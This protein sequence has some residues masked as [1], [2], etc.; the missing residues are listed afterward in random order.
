MAD[1]IKAEENKD[2]VTIIG[3]SELREEKERNANSV[4]EELEA[5]EEENN[6]EL[7]YSSLAG[8]VKESFRIN[9]DAR[10]NSG[11][12]QEMIDSMYDVN[13]EYTG[14]DIARIR[15][16][17]HGSTIFMN[18]PMQKCSVLSQ[19]VKD[20][21]LGKDR[22]WDF[23]PSPVKDLPPEI[24]MQ[25][26]QQV[27]M[28]FGEYV[29]RK[30]EEKQAAYQQQVQAAQKNGGPA[31]SA[32]EAS[33]TLRELNQIRRDIIDATMNEID[34]EAL[35]QAKFIKAQVED[36]LVEG[37][38][39]EALDEFIDYFSVFPTAFMKG[40][41]IVKKKKTTW[42][43]GRPTATEEYCFENKCPS[44][45]DMYP[46]PNQTTIEDG[47]LIEHVRY[48]RKEVYDLLKMPE[49]AGYKKDAIEEVLD[50]QVPNESGYP[51]W[52][53]DQIE[54]DKAVTEK[55]GYQ[56]EA[57]TNVIHGMHA[58]MSVPARL[59]I[60]WGFK[61]EDLEGAVGNEE[62]STEI[63][64][65]DEEVIKCKVLRDPFF[66]RPYY[67]ASFKP[68][69]GSFWGRSLPALMKSSTRMCNAT[70]RAL[71]NNMGISSGPQVEVNIDRLADDGSIESMYPWKIWQT[72]SDMIGGAG[73]AVNFFQ[74]S[75]NANDLLGVYK[76]FEQ[77]GDDVTG[78]PKFLS[79]GDGSTPS[80][81]PALSLSVL[82]SQATKGIKRSVE[83]I[84]LGVIN[85]RVK[86]QFY[87]N[88][89]KNPN[90]T[91]TGD[92]NIVPVP[93][94]EQASEKLRRNEFLQITANP[95]DQ[96]IMGDEGR[97]ALIREISKDLGMTE[98]IVPTRMEIAINSE[99]RQQAQQ[100]AQQSAQELEMQKAQ[101]G[102]QSTDRQIS[103]QESMHQ[104]SLQQDE[105]EMQ[106]DYQKHQEELAVEMQKLQADVATNQMG[107][108][109]TVAKQ[110][111]ADDTKKTMF[112]KELA[113]KLRTGK[114][115][116]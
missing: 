105:Q 11:I 34:K 80:S 55:R 68:I 47:D 62:I 60:E 17:E 111:M 106:L 79:G 2:G 77:K 54:S 90:L 87:W 57:N 5:M 100:Q 102:Y 36:D 22:V 70:A 88:L 15:E 83:N 29:K 8:H 94:I 14:K 85:P 33:Y 72:K 44:P 32:V 99:K 13:G 41:I 16:V 93:V 9:Q 51:S 64:L 65:I 25:I 59:L 12:E 95:V 73:P 103:G 20:I 23:K 48:S 6:K 35:Y 104:L 45:F 53:A 114:P 110:Q 30:Q 74:P 21:L 115:G 86:Y 52:M 42:V 91:F 96:A 4:T 61:P 98:E 56:F 27:A 75:S 28:E 66:R 82:M 63:I 31:P 116:V 58:W 78:V 7:Q 50:R 37:G 107:N 81:M 109:T 108:Q 112:H 1:F 19:W 24:K 26:E 49:D 3:I 18:N 46:S 92:V 69:P 38:F 67:K 113:Y 76:D 10:R 84:F 40:P 43:Q 39:N 89:L 101:I 71:A 97:G